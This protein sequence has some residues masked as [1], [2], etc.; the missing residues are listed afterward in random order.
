MTKEEREN[1]GWALVTELLTGLHGAVAGRSTE[2]E[3]LH[4]YAATNKG[5][6]HPLASVGCVCATHTVWPR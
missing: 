3:Q 1:E 2:G 4:A 6:L 5:R